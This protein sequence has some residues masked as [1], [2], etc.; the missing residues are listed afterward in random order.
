MGEQMFLPKISIVIPCYCVEKYLNRCLNSIVNQSLKDIEIILVDDGSLDNVPQMCDDWQR[1][2][3]RIK[4]IHKRNEGLG[5]ARNS[6]LNVA[7]GE[8]VAFI[9]SDDFVDCSMF[10]SL[11]KEAKSSNADAVFCGF[12]IEQKDG[13][14]KDCN[15][16]QLRTV[17]E[18]NGVL[19]FM[20]DMIASA[21]YEPC[22]RKFQMSVWHS[23]YKR[24]II[25]QN[26]ILFPSERN[27]VS[28]DIPFQV[29]FLSKANRIV[30]VPEVYYFYC[31]N[32]SSLSATYKP[33][34]I[35]LYKNL[36]ELLIQ[37][38]ISIPNSKMRINR[39]YI[40]FLRHNLMLLV[41]STRIDKR[42]LIRYVCDLDIWNE[43]KAEFKPSFLPYYGGVCYYLMSNNHEWLLWMYFM[44]MCKVIH[45]CRFCKIK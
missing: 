30:Y 10:E 41:N 1:Q 21:P 28:E 6:G 19:N 26:N 2:D 5:F 24:E 40:G 22:E 35:D 16:I 20:L 37:K 38:T 17:F 23:I 12:R 14:W 8:Y 42:Q 7:S 43:I 36:R 9:D 11:Y 18:G 33:E 44:I 25:F 32:G 13:S 4:V 31:L 27:V 29:D 39:L 15:E 3:S 34:K 45:F